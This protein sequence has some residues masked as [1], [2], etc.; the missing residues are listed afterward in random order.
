MQIDYRRGLIQGFPDSFGLT[1]SAVPGSLQNAA[2]FA[3]F[4][5]VKDSNQGTQ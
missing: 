4:V 2:R 5:E 1:V 3:A